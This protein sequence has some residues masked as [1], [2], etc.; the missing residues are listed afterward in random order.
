[1]REV[2]RDYEH[3]EERQVFGVEEGMGVEARVK[4]ENQHGEQ[5]DGPAAK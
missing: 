4:Q 2:E 1:M 3:A 5:R